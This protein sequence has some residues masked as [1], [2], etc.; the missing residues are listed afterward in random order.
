MSSAAVEFQRRLGASVALELGEPYKFVK[1]RLELRAPSPAGHNTVLLSGSNKYS[2]YIQVA[3]HFGCHFTA[4]NA[5][6]RQL[7]GH[8]HFAHISQYSPNKPSMSGLTYAEPVTWSVDI[9]TP[10]VTLAAELAAAIRGVA[11]PFFARFATMVTAR[12]A[13]AANDSWCFGGPNFWHSLLMLDLALGDAA[14]FDARSQRLGQSAKQ[15][16]NELLAIY[17]RSANDV[18]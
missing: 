7:K 6:E 2:P 15:Q 16:A 5:V 3:F 18:A 4:V 1:S 12:D 9:E 14:H 13:V 8:Q 10:P 17:A 11:Q